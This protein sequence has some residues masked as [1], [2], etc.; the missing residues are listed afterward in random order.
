MR[1]ILGVAICFVL[2]SAGVVHAADLNVAV[3]NVQKVA[4]ECDA[5]QEAKTALE[6]AYSKQKTEIEAQRAALEK[7][8]KGMTAKSTEAQQAEFRRMQREY[9]DKANAYVRSVQADEVRIRK[10]IDTVI[11]EAA[12]E[13]AKKKGYTIILDSS[14][15]AIYADP[16]MDV[17]NDMLTEANT[18]WKNSKKK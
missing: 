6:K 2:L 9:S 13:L 15:A 17:T 3:F 11:T 7:K 1:K 8:A 18:W 16:S 10:D 5:L 4:S 14:T 12:K